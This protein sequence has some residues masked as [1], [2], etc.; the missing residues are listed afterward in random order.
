LPSA[1]DALSEANRLKS[2][3]PLIL[4]PYHSALQA[5]ARMSSGST[6]ID[7]Y[8][9]AAE[10]ARRW[11]GVEPTCESRL[12]LGESLLGAK[13]DIEAS[14]VLRGALETSVCD[15]AGALP[16]LYLA[17]ALTRRGLYS[18]AEQT[19]VAAL[20]RASKDAARRIY[21]LLGF[22]YTK[23]QRI[24]EAVHAY[25]LAGDE[26]AASRVVENWKIVATD[27][28]NNRLSGPHGSWIL[29]SVSEGGP[30]DCMVRW[31]P[32]GC[33]DQGGWRGR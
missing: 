26:A 6:K 11:V 7:F 3:D 24:D 17:G 29:W 1:V 19:L 14:E 22:V 10:V 23:T 16:A 33:A 28:G 27:C 13:A 32:W 20:S 25:T 15:P 31:E 21:G 4:A 30:S 18:E 9:K 5:T 2:G 8:E 12:A